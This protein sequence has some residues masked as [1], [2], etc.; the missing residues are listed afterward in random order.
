LSE[1]SNNIGIGY[2]AGDGLAA[3]SNNI[4][5]GYDIDFASNSGSNQ[6]NIGNA[7]YGTGIDGTNNTLSNAYIAIGTSTPSTVARFTLATTTTPQLSLSAGANLAQWTFRN[8]GG[9]LYLSTTTVAGTATTS[10]SA[11]EIAGGGFGTTTLRGLNISGLATSTS[12]V[13]FNITGGCYAVNGTCVGG[14]SF[15]NTLANGGTATTTFYNGGVV[16]SD[17]LSLTQASSTA[18][19]YFDSQN[20]RLGLGTSSPYA[21]LS[22]V[23]E[24]VATNISATSTT[25][26]ST[27]AG[28][29]N[30]GNGAINY[31]F[32]T[33]ITSIPNLTIG[34]TNFEAD[35]GILSWVDMGVTSAEANGTEE[36]YSA[37]IDGNPVL[38]VFGRSNGSG[39]LSQYGLGIGTTTTAWLATFASSTQP[40]LSLSSGGEPACRQAGWQT[41]R[42]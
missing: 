38:T 35:S 17:G 21:R 1:G 36:S 29:L 10:I 2:R 24:I 16:F 20:N 23:G 41:Q 39:G 5:L 30:V 19:F 3:G 13:G 42:P 9:N 40:Q 37:Q 6:L 8:A 12:N 22:V 33:G 18:G 28:G 32:S 26:T 27:I 14:S 4:I 15:S 7:I 11:F 25:A 34:A 31:D